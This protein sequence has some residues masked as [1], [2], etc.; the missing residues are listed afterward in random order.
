MKDKINNILKNK[1]LLVILAVIIL[2]LVALIIILAIP[3]NNSVDKEYEYNTEIVSLDTL[4]SADEA[5]I[6]KLTG[7]VEDTDQKLAKLPFK[8]EGTPLVITAIGKYSGI[9]YDNGSNSEVDDVFA[10]VVQNTSD[11]IISYSN[12]NLKLNDSTTCSFSPTNIPA[13][14]SALVLP[15]N[16]TPLYSDVDT[17]KVSD[18]MAVLTDSLPLLQG[19]VGVDYKD[20]EFIVTNL[21]DEPL[22][23]VY[24][25]Y[26]NM[27]QGNAYLG[28]MTYSV[29]AEDV[30]PYETY[31]VEAE[32][33]DPEISVIISVESIIPIG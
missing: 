15:I 19:T 20:G 9:Q 25:R 33:Y 7:F 23:D 21:T 3:N 17:F 12:F 31:F 32:K 22:G 13:N 26:K 24:I 16:E 11:Q 1:A 4:S 30:Q 14:C 28:G 6:S 10:I 29:H 2:V 8:I 18:G 27:S 5:D